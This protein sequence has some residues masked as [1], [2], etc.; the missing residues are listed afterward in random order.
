MTDEEIRKFVNKLSTDELLPLREDLVF[1]L[2]NRARG[3]NVSV[4]KLIKD[5]MDEMEKESD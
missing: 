3:Q 2:I 4:E 5:T 1:E